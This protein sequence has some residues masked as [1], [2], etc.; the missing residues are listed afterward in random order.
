MNTHLPEIVYPKLFIPLEYERC[1]IWLLRTLDFETNRRAKSGL[2][3]EDDIDSQ[4]S[5]TREVPN[6][7][8]VAEGDLVL[9]RDNECLLGAAIIQDIQ[10]TSL[11]KEKLYCP[12]CGSSKLYWRSKS[13]DWRCDGK[14]LRPNRL[15]ADQRSTMNPVRRIEI[16]TSYTARYE[17]TWSDLAGALL[18]SQM[19]TLADAERWNPQNSIVQLNPVK[20]LDFFNQLDITSRQSIIVSESLQLPGGFVTGTVRRRLGQTQFRAH[21]VSKYKNRCAITGP[22]YLAALDA[23][24]LYSYAEEGQHIRGGGLLMRKDLHALF[25]RGLLGV[26]ARQRVALHRDL[27]G[28]QH[29]VLQGQELQVSIGKTEKR[30]LAK[31]F[32]H[33]SE[34]LVTS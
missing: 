25:D 13:E 32:E 28:T 18:A 21:L 30:L 3:Y 11:E 19:N 5:Y 27:E 6:S 23:A 2:I 22:C 8:Q 4:Y 33:Y 17:D 9:L 24:H 29:E 16:T 14:C 1:N 12:T 7:Q 20:V 15:S 31:H 10:K 34:S 26:D